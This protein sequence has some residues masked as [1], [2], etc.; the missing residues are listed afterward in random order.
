MRLYETT[1]PNLKA[2]TIFIAYNMYLSFRSRLAAHDTAYSLFIQLWSLLRPKKRRLIASLQSEIVID[3][4]PRSAN[5]YFVSFFEI[6]QGRPVQVGHH[7]HESWQFRFAEKHE[8][9]CVVLIREPL[10]A[11]SSAMLRDPRVAPDTLL[12]NYVRLYK[13][14]LRHRKKAVIAPFDVIIEDANQII[15]AVNRTYGTKFKLM[16]TEWHGAVADRVAAKDRAHFGSQVL[17]PIRIAAPSKAK[18]AVAEQLRS[19]IKAKHAD[20]LARA[21]EVYEKIMSI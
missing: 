11:V 7:L 13:N 8:I 6:A 1:P 3:G 17:D 19:D 14:L 5:T 10:A 2:R 9:P 16:N 20:D 12:N 4:F 21:R 15:S 18:K